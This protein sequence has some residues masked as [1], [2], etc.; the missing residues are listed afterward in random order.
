MIKSFLAFSQ[1]IENGNDVTSSSE[2]LFKGNPINIDWWH[3]WFCGLPGGC[4]GREGRDLT[5]FENM[6]VHEAFYQCENFCFFYPHR[7]I[8]CFDSF[9]CFREGVAEEEGAQDAG[10]TRAQFN[11]L[12]VPD[13]KHK[14]CIVI[15]VVKN[16]RW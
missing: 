3:V 11:K 13:I 15:V 14:T 9:D 2:P 10:V 8:V 6:L 1:L 5:R 16:Q 12:V 7:W 4:A